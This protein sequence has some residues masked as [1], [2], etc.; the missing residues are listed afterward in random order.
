MKGQFNYDNYET[1]VNMFSLDIPHTV[2]PMVEWWG[3]QM[4]YISSCAVWVTGI[5]FIVH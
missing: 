1:A 2:R 3:T 4:Q 5:S